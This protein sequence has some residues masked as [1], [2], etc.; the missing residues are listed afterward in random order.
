MSWNEVG[1]IDARISSNGIVQLAVSPDY[2][3]DQSLL[4]VTFDGVSTEHSLWRSRSGG[5]AWER[6]F[7]GTLPD[8]DG[9]SLVGF[10]PAYGKSARTLFVAGV[11]KG[12]PAIWK[13]ADGGQ[14]FRMSPA[15][16]QVDAWAIV[17]DDSLF[18]ASYNGSNG[19]IFKTEDSGVSY[20]D[21]TTSGSQP[22]KS[23]ALSPDYARDGAILAGNS[24]GS[25]YFSSDNGTSFKP[26]PRDASS[27]P[28]TGSVAVAF[29]S[30]FA[31]NKTVYAASNSAAKGIY[32]LVINKSTKWE[33]VDSSLPANGTMV[34]LAASANGTL[35]GVNSQTTN[36][37]TNK[38]GVERTLI[39]RDAFAVF[40]TVTVGFDDGANL[41]GLWL[42][43]DQLFSI[44]TQNTRVM[45][46]IDSLARPVTLISPADKSANIGTSG[47]P[48]KWEALA[49]ATLYK[50]QLS[51]DSDFSANVTGFEGDTRASSARLPA[52]DLDT[53][54]Y[55]RVRATKPVSSLW[56][57]VNSFSTGN[58]FDLDAPELYSPKVARK[59]C[60]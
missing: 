52:L 43:G 21:G 48:I 1:L 40:E 46:F 14:T 26:L 23:I 27:P 42:S 22:L 7:A 19:L 24:F 28:L 31:A 45:T 39:P 13:S 17:N 10:S 55:W 51:Y 11:S 32:R 57:A 58:G 4:M 15:P 36:I 25:V 18:L 33:R 35:Y 30:E 3:R 2:A 53:T 34:Q 54:Y 49:G 5:E 47:V 60:R 20:S 44:D 16:G 37:A 6:V 50:W 8:V 38:G 56:S 9:L 41:S 29:D 12:N 59:A